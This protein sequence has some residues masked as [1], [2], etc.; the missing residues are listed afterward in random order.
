MNPVPPVITMC[1]ILFD[2]QDHRTGQ[3][4][5]EIIFMIPRSSCSMISPRSTAA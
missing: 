3:T 2:Y 5:L 4:P 1:M